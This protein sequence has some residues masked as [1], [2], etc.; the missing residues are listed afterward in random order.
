M[1][2]RKA[3]NTIFVYCEGQSEQ[4][5]LKP[6]VLRYLG[7]DFRKVR[8]GIQVESL[9]GIHHV[10]DKIGR[11][12]RDK[13]RQPDVIAVFALVDLYGSGFN[14]VQQVKAELTRRVSR[15]C[16]A[17][18][19]PHVAVNELEAWIFADEDALSNWL[20]HRV[21]PFPTPERLNR[22]TPPASR[23]RTLTSRHAPRKLTTKRAFAQELFG[24]V[25]AEKIYQKCPN[26]RA[27]VDDLRQTAGA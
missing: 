16:R 11:V 23:L 4:D 3:S 8:C 2:A 22:Q 12:T 14:T 24:Q 15:D 13:L 19:H 25:D 21:G 9:N 26:F 7:E 27:F 17:Q 6:L 5:I 10:Y 20:G 1:R 18:F